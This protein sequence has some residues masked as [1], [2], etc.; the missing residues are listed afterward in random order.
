[1]GILNATPDSFSD[2]GKHSDAGAAADAALKMIADGADIIDIGGESTRP[3][4]ASVSAEE[5]KARVT[6]IIKRLHA[7]TNAPI[8]IDTM[9]PEVAQAAFDAGA[10]IWNDVMAL[11]APGALETA[12]KLGA[13]VILM[14]MQ[15]A[16]RTMQANPIYADVVGEVIAFLQARAAAAEEAGLG[17][18]WIDPGIGFGKTLTHNLALIGNLA[19]IAAETKKPLLF[20]ASRKSMIAKIDPSAAA[21]GDRLGGSLALALLAAQAGADIIRVHDVRETVQALRVTLAARDA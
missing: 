11:Q 19:R 2:G 14:H 16:P 9:K 17:D 13:P 5:E 1:M 12:A 21:A 4:A 7:Q 20:G 6:P 18:I 10:S 3:G 15:G 8:S